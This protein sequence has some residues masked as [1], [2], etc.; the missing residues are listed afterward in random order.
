MPLASEFGRVGRVR[1]DGQRDRAGQIQHA[2]IPDRIL[3][4]VINDQREVGSARGLGLLGWRC[5][6]STSQAIDHQQGQK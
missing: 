4:K 3:A 5:V 6:N 1:H 2:L